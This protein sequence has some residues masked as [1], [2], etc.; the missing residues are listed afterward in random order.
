VITPGS[1]LKLA[2]NSLNRQSNY[3]FA[4]QQRG[5][6]VMLAK[7]DAD[8]LWDVVFTDQDGNPH[9][10]Q[11]VSSERFTV[12]TLAPAPKRWWQFW[13]RG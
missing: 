4:L 9:L 1:T 10:I 12:T 13:R 11:G 3:W 6:P 7:I 8:G 2:D 5:Q